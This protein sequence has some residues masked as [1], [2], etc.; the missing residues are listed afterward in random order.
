[1]K[2]RNE[3]LTRFFLDMYDRDERTL[4]FLIDGVVPKKVFLLEYYSFVECEMISEIELLLKKEKEKLVAKCKE[5]GI[6][7]SNKTLTDAAR[8]LYTI[9]FINENI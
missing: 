6:K 3:N 5:T 4:A 1:M 2:T 7:F 8:V 9:N